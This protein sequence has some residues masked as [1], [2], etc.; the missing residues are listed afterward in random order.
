MKSVRILLSS[1]LLLVS[2]ARFAYAVDTVPVNSNK[3]AKLADLGVLF[4]NILAVISALASFAAL[5]MLIWGGFKYMTSQGDPKA[6]DSARGTLTWAVIGLI[7]IIVSWL[8]MVFIEQFTGVNVTKFCIGL[9][10]PI[11]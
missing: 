2:Q 7:M 6:V 8:V 11:N 1:F 10:C 3:V 5:S 9:T 4:G